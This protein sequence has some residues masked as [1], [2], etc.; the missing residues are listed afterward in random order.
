[1]R[2]GLRLACLQLA[3]HDIDR[4]EEALSDALRMVDEAARMRPDLVVLPECVYP[5]YYLLDSDGRDRRASLRPT[6]ELLALFAERARAHACY[7]AVGALDDRGDGAPRNAA[8]LF[9]PAGELVATA[10][11][12]FLWHFDSRWFV[13]GTATEPVSTPWGP[14]GLLICADARMPEIPRALALQGARVLIDPTDLVSTGKDPTG[15]TN[16]QVEY[17]LKARAIENQ[18]WVA[19][20]NKVGVEQASI[21]YCGHSQ[22]I[23]PQGDVAAMAGSS[24]PEIVLAEI[25]L[26]LGEAGTVD[27]VFAPLADRRPETYGDL[28]R[29]LDELPVAETMVETVIPEET[30]LVVA[31]LQLDMEVPAERLLA[32][33]RKHIRN[34]AVQGANLVV[35]PQ[36][37]PAAWSAWSPAQSEAVV[38]LVR[39]IT[40]EQDV[41][42]V[43][44]ADEMDRDRRY[45]TAFFVARGE[46][47]ARYRKS[48][49][50]AAERGAYVPGEG[51]Y[52]VVRTKAGNLGI[53]LGYEGLLPEVAR[54]LALRGADVIAWPCNFA[55]SRHEL[56]ARTR[57]AENRVFVAASNAAGRRSIGE[58]LIVD[59]RGAVLAQAFRDREQ[60][61]AATL[62]L[63]EARCKAIVPGTDAVRGRRPASYGPL[64]H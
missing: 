55:A 27:G 24:S 26:P 45:R 18:A 11:K 49:L 4:A 41:A 50:D 47:V 53:M 15:L 37:P 51:D 32:A 20:A 64:V 34:L 61:V 62:T 31:A 29:P 6:S 30:C 38:S 46:M 58:S 8:F 14:T 22:I 56:F 60:T 42:V 40:A 57:A 48:H 35:L 33:L 1:M 13:P 9:G 39:D 43:V 52:A 2:G 16:A 21:V 19:V 23:T 3:A 54:I 17:M 28:V 5:A 7:I 63:A 10:H 44:V 12:Q 36:P 25:P 59:P